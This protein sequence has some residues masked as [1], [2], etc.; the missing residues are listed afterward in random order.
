MMIHIPH[1]IQQIVGAA[2]VTALAIAD[3]ISWF[4]AFL[5]YEVWPWSS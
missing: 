3:A 2:K 4:V 1:L 5:Y